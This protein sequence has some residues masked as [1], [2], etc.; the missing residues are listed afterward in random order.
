MPRGYTLFQFGGSGT[1]SLKFFGP[2]RG[3]GLVN[4]CRLVMKEVHEK[5]SYTLVLFVLVGFVH[6]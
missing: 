4:L 5:Q 2:E 1:K 6:G 3:V